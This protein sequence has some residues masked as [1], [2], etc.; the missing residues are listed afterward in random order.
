VPNGGIWSTPRDIAKFVIALEGGALLKPDGLRQMLMIPPGGR[1][2]GLGIM[3]VRDQYMTLIGHNGSDPGYTS[4]YLIEP[5]SGDAI[6]LM[7]NY[8]VGTTDLEAMA[9]DFLQRL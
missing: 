5:T 1:S 7:R 2:Y 9:K 4:E 6:I 8:N 3:I